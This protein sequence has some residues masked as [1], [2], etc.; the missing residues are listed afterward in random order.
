MKILFIGDISGKPGRETVAKVLPEI[1]EKEKVDFVI[2]NAENC[3]GGRGITRK[4]LQELQSD[5]IDYFTAGEHVWTY[6]EFLEELEDASLPMVRPYNYEKGNFIPGKGLAVIDLGAYK[7]GI[8]CLIG[9]EFMR[10]HVANPFWSADE[11]LNEFETKGITPGKDIIIL[12][13]HAEATS[14][15][16]CLAYYLRNRVTAVI[17]THTHVATADPRI[18]ETTAFVSDAGMVGPRDASLWVDFENVIHNF[19]Y[20]YKRAFKMQENGQRI[21]NS[22]LIETENNIAVSIKR[23]DKI[24][25]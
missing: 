6:K 24:L 10:E 13:F 14:E 23:L 16:I 21:F 8:G 2:A 15:K 7:M 17:G 1:R 3:S 25:G 18:I 5:G 20:P 22:V 9:R 19:K 4:A 12:D 11:M